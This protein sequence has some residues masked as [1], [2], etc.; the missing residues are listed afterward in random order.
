MNETEKG[1]KILVAI[2]AHNEQG[3]ILNVVNGILNETRGL[4]TDIVVFDDASTDD[5]QG[6]LQSNNIKNLRIKKSFGLGNVFAKMTQH[7][8]EKGY[9]VLLTIDGD[10]QFDPK[11]VQKILQPILKKEAGMVT[12]SRFINGAST[13]NISWIKKFGNITGARYVSS[14]LKDRFYD[15]T[16]GFR[17]YSRDAILKLHTFSDFTYTQEVFLNLGFKKIPIIEVPIRTV[18]FKDRKSK[19]VKNIFSYILKSLKIILRSILIYSPM[20]LFGKL[21]I[22]CF[23]IT[24]ISGVFIFFWDQS[25]GG[26]TPF[27][28]VG[29]VAMASAIIGVILFSVGIL[30][31]IT[32]R[33][34][35]TAEEHLYLTKKINYGNKG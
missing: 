26:V 31:Q 10:G 28:W 23:F 5:T 32:S 15:V 18:Y 7:F 22:F 25:T 20:R 3:S 24:L 21:G 6:I 19:M 12:G 35:L 30:L 16:C 4:D 27:K 2:P 9:D 29:V 8:L 13:Q 11:D 17:A 34:Q 1:Q 33:L 14:V